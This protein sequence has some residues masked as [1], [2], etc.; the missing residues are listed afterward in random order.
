MP[1]WVWAHPHPHRGFGLLAP[2]HRKSKWHPSMIRGTLF[3]LGVAAWRDTRSTGSYPGIGGGISGFEPHDPFEGVPSPS[4]NQARPAPN[5]SRKSK[6]ALLRFVL[7][8]CQKARPRRAVPPWGLGGSV[9]GRA[10]GIR[11]GLLGPGLCP[12]AI[13]RPH[14]PK[15]PALSIL[16]RGVVL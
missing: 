10:G 3:L 4:R 16:L 15:V 14:S 11:R 9:L 6:S 2:T 13:P 7:L 5:V 8:S 1:A 12:L